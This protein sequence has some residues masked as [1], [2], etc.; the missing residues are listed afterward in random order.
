MSLFELQEWLGHRCPSSTQHYAKITPTKLAKAYSDAGYFGRNIRAVEVL[1]DQEAI[2]NGTVLKGEPWKYYDLGHG[3]YTY[4]FFEH[5]PHRMACAKC[6]FYL[7]KESSRAQLLEAKTNLERMMQEIPLRE[8]ERAAVEGGLA[9]LEKLETELT[10]V[11]TPGGPTPLEIRK[12]AHVE[13]PI[14]QQALSC[15]NE[16]N[17]FAIHGVSAHDDL[18]A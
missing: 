5:C 4:D 3:Y 2:R 15:N 14:M 16:K 17:K 18:A 11:P 13:L 10:N 12:K 1:I 9:A 8:D 7:P 6:S